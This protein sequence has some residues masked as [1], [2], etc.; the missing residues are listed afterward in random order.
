MEKKSIHGDDEKFTRETKWRT[1]DGREIPIK[2]LKDT[3]VLNL[4][5]YTW[6]NVEKYKKH[7][8]EGDKTNEFIIEIRQERY[9]KSLEMYNLINAEIELRRLDRSK[10]AGGKNLPF[11]KDGQWLIWK[12]GDRLPTPIPNSIDFIKPLDGSED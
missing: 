2:D 10:V 5:N 9:Y 11:K 3:H 12:E 1:Y 7:L 8:E 4:L 6:R